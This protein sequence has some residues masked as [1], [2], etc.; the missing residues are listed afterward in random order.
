MPALPQVEQEALRCMRR[1]DTESGREWVEQAGGAAVP[2]RR[3]FGGRRQ[4]G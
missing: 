4:R 3:T 1:L 2:A